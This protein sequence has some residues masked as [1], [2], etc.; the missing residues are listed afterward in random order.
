[1]M[2][3]LF[4]IYDKRLHKPMYLL[5]CNLAVVDILYT[6]SS[7]PTMIGVLVAGV[8]TI[9]YVPCFIAMFAF[10]LGGVM[11]TFALSIMAFDRLIAISC[12]FKYHSYLTN[13]RT[14][15]LT[16]ILWIVACGFASYLQA[17]LLPLPHCHSKLKHNFC[18]FAAI[19]RTTC[20]DVTPYFNL[21][22][23]IIF[24]YLFFTFTFICLS[25]ILII[26]F[27]KLSSNSNKR[28]MGSTCLS[29]LIVVTCY[30]CP[31]FVIVV[32]TR[33]GV[34]LTLEARHG[35]LIGTIL[36]PSLVNP[37]VYCLRTKEIRCKIL[38][39][40]KSS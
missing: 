18:E 20:V 28:K 30:Y 2:N 22:A 31:V 27:V 14:L 7:S 15:V 9:S 8:K 26:F 40:F 16:Y 34:V 6:S 3:I 4:I 29:H 36:G 21:V 23:V 12:P 33:M 35:L 38:G 13:V 25:Y 11:V 10:H 39:I 19:I 17:I 5:I 37:F 24:I 32:L 1:M